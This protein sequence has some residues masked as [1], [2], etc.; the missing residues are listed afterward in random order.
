M[1]RFDIAQTALELF[2]QHIAILMADH[3]RFHKT[4][5]ASLYLCLAAE[6]LEDGK[7]RIYGLMA[8]ASLLL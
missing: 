5:F 1:T 4:V 3:D 2:R 8:L 7:W 6:H